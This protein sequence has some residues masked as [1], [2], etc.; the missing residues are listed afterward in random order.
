MG[1][2]E[3]K[4]R[5]AKLAKDREEREKLERMKKQK[6]KEAAKAA[7]AE[8]DASARA[9]ASA[10]AKAKAKAEAEAK[11]KAKADAEAIAARQKKVEETSVDLDNYDDEDVS[12]GREEGKEE[13]THYQDFSPLVLEGDASCFPFGLLILFYNLFISWYTTKP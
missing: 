7:E 5:D 9:E 2:A 10:K 13:G 12:Q 8:A 11:A 6:Q 1:K 3:M 4:A